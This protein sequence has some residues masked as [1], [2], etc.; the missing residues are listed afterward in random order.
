ME[1]RVL[2]YFLAVAREGNITKAADV[3]HVSQ[4]ALSMQLKQ[5]EDELGK[6]LFTRSSHCISLTEEGLLLK[7]RAEDIVGMVEK[8][9]DEFRSLGELN[10]GDIRLGC[11][12]S[13]GMGLIADVCREMRKEYPALRVHIY[14]SATEEATDK[15]DKGLLDF[16]LLAQDADFSR[17]ESIVF[18]G[19]DRWGLIMKAEDCLA[20][21][22]SIKV[23]DLDGLPLI[24]S[25][26]GMKDELLRWAGKHIERFDTAATYNLLYNAAQMVR[27]GYG[28]ALSFEGLV[29]TD[30]SSDLAF[31]PLE[32]ELR[33]SRV[34]IWKH[35]QVFTPIAKLFLEKLKLKLEET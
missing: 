28:Y 27:H 24:V 14:S 35:H 19:F 6:K 11:A 17:Y 30:G 1:F 4:P 8:T 33:S 22:A 2:R 10:G 23:E 16:V 18:P 20:E 31:R 13:E 9:E 7:K 34:L 5:L 32:P 15:L 12:E 3:M 26:Q 21:K 29:E 25:R